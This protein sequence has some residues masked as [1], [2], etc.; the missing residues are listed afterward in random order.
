VIQLEIPAFTVT[1]FVLVEVHD[2][3][4]VV[5][6]RVNVQV[7]VPAFTD[8]EEALFAPTI[9]PLPLMLHK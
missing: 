5:S 9:V 8:T 6:V 7:V 3:L 4:E 1:T 2:P